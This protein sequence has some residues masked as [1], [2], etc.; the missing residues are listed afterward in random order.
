MTEDLVICSKCK[1]IGK[2][3]PG[4]AF[5]GASLICKICGFQNKTQYYV[6]IK[7]IKYLKEKYGD[8]SLD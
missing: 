5:T 2:I 1:S 6:T 3:K 4:A 8:Y 7:E